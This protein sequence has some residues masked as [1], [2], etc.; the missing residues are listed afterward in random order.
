M[1]HGIAQKKT[2][3]AD[4]DMNDI[5]TAT[6]EKRRQGRKFFKNRPLRRVEHQ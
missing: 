5:V 3:A 4:P 2:E 6:S 1:K